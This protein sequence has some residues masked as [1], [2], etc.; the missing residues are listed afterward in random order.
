MSVPNHQKEAHQCLCGLKNTCLCG[1]VASMREAQ[2][3]TPRGLESPHERVEEAPQGSYR[4]PSASTT[5][6][7]AP[8]PAVSSVDTDAGRL[9][10]SHSSIQ[11]QVPMYSFLPRNVSFQQ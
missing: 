6:K 9:T 2:T 1:L 4:G 3:V 5:I 11:I 7:A 8:S 10:H